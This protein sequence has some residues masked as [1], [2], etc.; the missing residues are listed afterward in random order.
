MKHIANYNQKAASYCCES[1]NVVDIDSV[2]VI[3]LLA[4]HEQ[5][6]SQKAASYCC[7]SSNVVD[8]AVIE[9]NNA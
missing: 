9:K 5:T 6:D 4:K 7:E 2:E 8:I 3:V 1:S